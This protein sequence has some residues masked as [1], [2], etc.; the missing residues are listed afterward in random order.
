MR[1]RRGRYVWSRWRPACSPGE[2]LRLALR[3]VGVHQR[4]H[5]ALV[6]A[7]GGGEAGGERACAW[8]ITCG[9][10]AVGVLDDVGQRRRGKSW[11]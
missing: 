9:C 5:H 1:W 7:K 10:A 2:V 4:Q 11:K 3:M 8:L 6:D